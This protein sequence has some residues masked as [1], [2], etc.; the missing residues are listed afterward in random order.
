ML[1]SLRYMHSWHFDDKWC[2]HK[3]VR[4]LENDRERG[5]TLAKVYLGNRQSDW[6]VGSWKWFYPIK[7]QHQV[8]WQKKFRKYKA[9]FSAREQINKNENKR[10]KRGIIF[11][12]ILQVLSKLNCALFFWKKNPLNF[13]LKFSFY[14]FKLTR[15][16]TRWI[17]RK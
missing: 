13:L 15:L 3:S 7:L 4:Q 14:V 5:W 16:L 8:F 1:S 9:G 10:F 11:M 12:C 2:L 17:W 6:S